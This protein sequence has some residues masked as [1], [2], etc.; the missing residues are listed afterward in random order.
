MKWFCLL[1]LLSLNSRAQ[2]AAVNTGN[3]NWTFQIKAGDQVQSFAKKTT[4]KWVTNLEG[5]RVLQWSALV[6][7]PWDFNAGKPTSETPSVELKSKDSKLLINTSALKSVV[8]LAD[9]R[10]VQFN[11]KTSKPVLIDENCA[12]IAALALKPKGPEAPF[13]IGTSCT[14]KNEEVTFSMSFPVEADLSNSTIFEK[15]GKGENY[16]LYDLKKISAAKVKIADFEFTF[17]GKKYAYG[18]N[19]LKAE[20]Q[21]EQIVDN[22]RFVFGAG[23]AALSF[24]STTSG[25]NDSK[26]Y[27]LFQLLPKNIWGNLNLGFSIEGTITG[28]KESNSLTYYQAYGYLGYGFKFSDSFQ[29]HP[30]VYE[31]ISNQDSSGGVNYQVNQVG[32]G[33]WT[34][35]NFSPQTFM[36]A[37]VI[38]ASFGSQVVKSHNLISASFFYNTWG[39]G[40]QTQ[41][42]TVVD[43]NENVRTFSQTLLS[44]QKMF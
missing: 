17:N 36:M 11:W 12:K 42:Y 27:L 9:G 37:E 8:K 39:L 4:W 38:S 35:W 2:E 44:L 13:F 10:E 23:M 33:F 43:V 34:K 25:I 22:S 30:R 31:V 18:L 14:I 20:S 16:R 29:L 5:V 24:K 1:L 32:A 15:T 41:T 6:E 28:L 3:F 21:G 19:S 26:P 40:V 7:T